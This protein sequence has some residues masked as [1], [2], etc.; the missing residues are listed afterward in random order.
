MFPCRISFLK[1]L[2][3]KD[4]QE[5]LELTQH[6]GREMR[7]DA[8]YMNRIVLSYECLSH[9]SG[10]ENKHN[11]RAWGTE[12][13]RAVQEVPPRF[14]KVMVWCGMHELRIIGPSFFSKLSVTWSNSKVMLRYYALPKIQELSGSP[15]FQQDGAPAHYFISVRQCMDRKFRDNWI[16]RVGPA[17]WLP[18]SPYLS[19]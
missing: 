1:Q 10:L 4:Y 18:R 19:L 8:G 3:P 12:N 9:T 5:R 6:C 16:G 14:E 7:N 17:A 13:P 2:L 15:I 11:A